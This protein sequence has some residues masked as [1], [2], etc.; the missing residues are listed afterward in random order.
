MIFKTTIDAIFKSTSLHNFGQV[1][2]L[3]DPNAILQVKSS[4]V[5]YII[6]KKQSL[7]DFK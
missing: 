3:I 6:H 2:W 7:S 5:N 4:V 1:F